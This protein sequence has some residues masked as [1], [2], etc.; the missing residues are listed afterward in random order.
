MKAL[1]FDDVLIVDKF[2]TITSRND[3]DTSVKLMGITLKVPMVSSNMT[4][5][6]DAKMATELRRLGAI[7]CLPR[8]GSIDDNVAVFKKS[9]G[10]TFVSIGLGKSELERAASL[11]QAGASAIVIDVAQ[12]GNVNVVH[13]T[14]ALKEIVK[15]NA[16]IMIGNFSNLSV[17]SAFQHA[18]GWAPDA[19]KVGI[20]GGSACITRKVTGCGLPTFES[21]ISLAAAGVPLVADG[22]I[23]DSGDMVKALAAGASAVMCGRL[24][25]ACEESPGEIKDHCKKYSGSA[26]AESYESQ[27]KTASY[28]AAEGE[29][30]WIPVTGTVED[31]V[32]NFNGG[33]R[34][35][36]TYN[37]AYTIKEL[38][39]NVEFVEVTSSGSKEN[40]AHGKN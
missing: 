29:T 17:Y 6:T 12:G 21:I 19:I 16:A 38:Q 20:G 36:M 31:L 28:R 25:A 23:R 24:F 10:E 8:F 34:S 3:V 27:G 32:N 2:S 14:K 11:F 39:K 1:S 30:Y 5:V 26:S 18:L 40:S 33:L 35:A 7:G 9:P 13:Q 4:C 22:G 15:N 37:N